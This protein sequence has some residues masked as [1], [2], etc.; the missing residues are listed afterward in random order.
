MKKH[1]CIP[2]EKI[3]NHSNN[4]VINSFNYVR[5]P[6]TLVALVDK[7]YEVLPCFLQDLTLLKAVDM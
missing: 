2:F 5:K 7:F 3:W 1:K 6:F 4:E